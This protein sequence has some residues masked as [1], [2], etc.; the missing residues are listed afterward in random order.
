[1]FTEPA[2]GKDRAALVAASPIYALSKQSPLCHLPVLLVNAEDDWYLQ[3]DTAEL[4]LAIHAAQRG[5]KYAGPAS[6]MPAKAAAGA[7]QA[8]NGTG[9]SKVSDAYTQI[10]EL[11]FL[12]PEARPNA[13]KAIAD[14]PPTGI[15]W[16]DSVSPNVQRAVLG[17]VN[18]FSIIT[19]VGRA[20]GPD[21][22]ADLLASFVYKH[23][24][25][26]LAVNDIS[27]GGG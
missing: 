18:H 8:L 1:M 15:K 12:E 27:A 20:G 23:G 19:G 3:E 22:L 4:D 24:R 2:F 7:T 26:R 11:R 17:G 5:L 16:V 6:A 21:P 25:R 14:V 9:T 10:Q 13:L